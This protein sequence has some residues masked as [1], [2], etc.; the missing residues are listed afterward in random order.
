MLD[1]QERF[2]IVN[3]FDMS[4]GTLEC[5]SLRESKQ[6][7]REFLG[8]ACVRHHEE[9][10]LISS[11]SYPWSI[12]SVQAGDGVHPQGRD[13]RW[14]VQVASPGDVDNARATALAHKD[15]FAIREIEDIVESDGRRSFSL[16]DRDGNWW[17]IESAP[18]DYYE[19]LFRK[20]D[21]A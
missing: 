19:N 7:Y 18:R 8:L 3:G 14:G 12:V 17:E 9:A 6:F 5:H 10:Q 15:Q 20:G 1:S 11:K 2:P 16:Q 4:H 21:R 13:Y